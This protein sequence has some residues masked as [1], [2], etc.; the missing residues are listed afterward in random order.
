MYIVCTVSLPM[1]LS[2]VKDLLEYM[3]PRVKK[4]I[5]IDV[6]DDDNHLYSGRYSRIPKKLLNKEIDVWAPCADVVTD[7]SDRIVIEKSVFIRVK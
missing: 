2:M 6:Y 5:H 4:D 3:D 7:D 1:R